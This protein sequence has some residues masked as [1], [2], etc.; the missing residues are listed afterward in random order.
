ML[1]G[2]IVPGGQLWRF[3]HRFSDELQQHVSLFIRKC[4]QLKQTIMHVKEKGGR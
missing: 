1:R 2:A 4:C 3:R